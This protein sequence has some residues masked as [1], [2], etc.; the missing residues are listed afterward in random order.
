[1]SFGEEMHDDLDDAAARFREILKLHATPIW[2]TKDGRKIPINKMDDGHV[3][4]T[5]NF[6]GRAIVAGED[7]AFT[8]SL[9]DGGSDPDG[10]ENLENSTGCQLA[11]AK[12]WRG[13]L[14]EEQ[15]KRAARRERTRPKMPW[16]RQ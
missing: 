10:L 11:V 3:E 8:L 4:N 14:I 15:A 2:T 6:L 13:I 12:A 5:I 9:F 7:L 1:M 16:E